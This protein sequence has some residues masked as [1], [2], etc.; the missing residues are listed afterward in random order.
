MNARRCLDFFFAG[1]GI[2][3]ALFLAVWASGATFGQRCERLHPGEAMAQE[4]CVDQLA[5][6]FAQERKMQ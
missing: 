3:S 1:L 6:K 4:Q 5:G 2:T